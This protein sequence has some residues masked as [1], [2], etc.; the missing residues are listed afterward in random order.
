MLGFSLLCVSYVLFYVI[1]NIGWYGTQQ[2]SLT[3]SES[4][5]KCEDL[6]VLIPFR[7]EQENLSILLKNINEL[8][9]APRKFIFIDDHSYDDWKGLFENQNNNSID[10]YSLGKDKKGK[11]EAIWEGVKRTETKYVLCWDADVYFKADYFVELQDLQP[12]DLIILPVHF[13]SNNTVQALG[14][15]DFYLANFVN[16]AS[17]YW[18]RPV[19]CNGA[20]LLFSKSTYLEVNNLKEHQHILSGDDMFLLRQMIKNKKTVYC[21]PTKTCTISTQSQKSFSSYLNQRMRWLGKSLYI[22]D[23]LLNFWAI[24]QFFYSIGFFTCFIYWIFEDP[25]TFV[26]FFI[27]KCGIDLLF[28]SWYFYSIKKTIFTFFIP[29]YG[30]IFPIYNLF[31]LSSFYIKKQKWKGRKLYN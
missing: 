17:A 5:I 12:A 29:V 10:V 30:L 31:I 18:L 13:K 8:K 16:Q 21:A 4:K 2:K 24:V 15:I 28:L 3:K 11:K 25:K 14:E 22:N 26:I 6:T 19:M 7:N 27:I 20:N 9:K 23:A 1:L